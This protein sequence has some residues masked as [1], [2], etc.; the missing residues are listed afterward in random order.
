MGFP[1]SRRAIGWYPG[2]LDAV[3]CAY[4]NGSAGG[5]ATKSITTTVEQMIDMVMQ[6]I[7]TK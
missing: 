7:G 3:C 1:Y 2:Q 5:R 6:G 4:Y